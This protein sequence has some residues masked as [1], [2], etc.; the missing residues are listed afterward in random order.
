MC[1]AAVH[2]PFTSV[3]LSQVSLLRRYK[4][5]L[6]PCW[7]RSQF[8]LTANLRSTSLIGLHTGSPSMFT[9]TAGVLLKNTVGGSDLMPSTVFGTIWL[10][11]ILA[12]TRSSA[13]MRSSS[14]MALSIWAV[15]SRTW[16]FASDG[17]LASVIVIFWNFTRRSARATLV[18]ASTFTVPGVALS[19]VVE[20][21][22]TAL[23]ATM[24]FC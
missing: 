18:S 23:N 16:S 24:C 8:V 3:A 1:P 5:L 17:K 15:I 9:I 13:M 2:G 20:R 7:N 19:A 22:D 21:Y 14:G 10:L 4:V 12:S 11:S 6:G